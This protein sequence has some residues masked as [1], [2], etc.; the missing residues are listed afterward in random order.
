MLLLKN[1]NLMVM[2]INLN[3]QTKEKKNVAKA[4]IFGWFHVL[5]SKHCTII[6]DITN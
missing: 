5:S 2:M 3:K 4:Q 1:Y 6:Y